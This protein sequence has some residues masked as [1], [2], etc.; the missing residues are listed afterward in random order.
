MLKLAWDPF[1]KPPLSWMAGALLRGM[2]LLTSPSPLSALMADFILDTRPGSERAAVRNAELLRFSPL[3]HVAKIERAEF[4]LV[5]TWFGEPGLWSPCKTPDGSLYAVV[6]M[7]AL[8]ES[9][10]QAAEQGGHSDGLAARAIARRFETG[11][12]AA[13]ENISGNCVIVIHDAP[14]GK[15]YLRTDPAGVFPVYSCQCSSMPVWG[16]H[17]DILAAVAGETGRVDE[18]SLAEFILA[19]TVTPPFTYYER[20]REV[21]LGTLIIFHLQEKRQS[22]R[23]YFTF[24][25]QGDPQTSEDELADVFV[26]AWRQAVRRRT[27]PRFGRPVVALSGGLDSRLILAAMDQPEGAVAFTCYDAPNRELKTAR[28]IARTVGAAFLPLQRS[29]DYYGEN[30]EA[31]VRISGGMG[32]FANNHFLGVLERLHAEGLQT[33]L[34]GCYCDY[35]FKALPLNRRIHWLSGRETVAP[36]SDAFYFEHWMPDTPLAPQVLQRWEERFPAALRERQD[37]AT[38]FEIEVRRTFPLCYEG[39]NQQ[40]LVPQRMTGWFPPLVDVELLRVYRRIPPRMKLNRRLFLKAARRVLAGS[41]AGRVPDTNTGARLSASPLGVALSCNLLR[42]RRRVRGVG[43]SLASDESWPDWHYYYRHSPV[44]ERLWMR[45]HPEAEDFFLRV[46]GW[47]QLPA[48]PADFPS[49]QVF[50]FVALLTQKLWWLQLPCFGDP[51][52]CSSA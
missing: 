52:S 44:L 42:L 4:S 43:H 20:I 30:A 29:A 11:G 1:A 18:V 14:R 16:S 48:R 32:T 5:L 41:P 8:D 37:D 24:D 6:G 47:S 7:V 49:D 13:L 15:L 10:W 19:S 23:R 9:E 26:A 17:P 25:F 2:S 40:R 28:A 50:L 34:T 12:S 45:P 39:D 22:Q 21:E 51:S 36:F 38:L 46:L 27:L 35:L 3:L 33:M 31:G